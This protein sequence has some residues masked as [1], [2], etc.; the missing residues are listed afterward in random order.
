VR[1]Q[2]PERCG[3][4]LLCSVVSQAGATPVCSERHWGQPRRGCA[5]VGG[6]PRDRRTWAPGVAHL[7]VTA[8]YSPPHMLRYDGACEAGHGGLKTRVRHLAAWVHRP[9]EWTLE[10]VARARCA[11]NEHGR[12]FGRQRPT[13]EQAW[14][15]RVQPTEEECDAWR[16]SLARHREALRASRTAE[17]G[18]SRPA[19]EPHTA[20]SRA[21]LEPGCLQI[22]SRR[23][24]L[25]V[26]PFFLAD[27]G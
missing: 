10:D 14:A 18:R 12:P 20:L 2:V 26:S 5:Q 25:R 3:A 8:L 15:G 7:G 17:P 16:A 22:K 9:G 13:P 1:H 21:L 4:R 19:L 23:G 6:S 24:S 11:G 27:I